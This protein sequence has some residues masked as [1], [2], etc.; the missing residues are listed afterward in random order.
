MKVKVKRLG[1]KR[2]G[3]GTAGSRTGVCQTRQTLSFQPGERA[4]VRL[5][6]LPPDCSGWHLS[7]HRPPLRLGA[8]AP[9]AGAHQLPALLWRCFPCRFCPSAFLRLGQNDFA[10]AHRFFTEILKIDPTNAV[11]RCLNLLAVAVAL[12][13]WWGG[14][15]PHAPGTEPS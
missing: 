13:G 3:K 4:A 5:E 1:E 11:V 15:A 10:E 7:Q 12:A 8:A 14:S 2:G 6:A 9:L